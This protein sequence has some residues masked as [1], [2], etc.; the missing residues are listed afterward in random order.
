[1]K[2]LYKYFSKAEEQIDSGFRAGHL[3][4]LREDFMG[5]KTRTIDE[6]DF[7]SLLSVLSTTKTPY[8]M[9]GGVAVQLYVEEPRFTSDVDL[10]IASFDDV[11]IEA[12]QDAG[13]KHTGTYE[14]SI[15]WKGPGGTIVQFSSEPWFSDLV[16][17]A[18]RIQTKRGELS[19]ADL[20]D[21]FLSKLKAAE[22]PRR[23]PSKR[24]T[25]LIDLRTMLD[26]HP[27][28]LEHYPDAEE[29]IAKIATQVLTR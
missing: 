1:M 2:S 26:E 15:N 8:A 24:M 21:L 14:H 16:S 11:P 25:D 4:L 9:I 27:N 22:E 6:A 10:A 28:L 13:F 29:Q 12:L 18:Q 17:D 23:R 19:V 7:A 5:K 20:P 3:R